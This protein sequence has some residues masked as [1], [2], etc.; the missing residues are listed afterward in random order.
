M[1]ILLK[2]KIVAEHFSKWLFGQHINLSTFMKC[3]KNQLWA[4]PAGLSAS[5]DHHVR[6]N[7]EN[8]LS[9]FTLCSFDSFIRF[10]DLLLIRIIFFSFQHPFLQFSILYLL[11]VC[12]KG[13][14]MIFSH[15]R[16]TCNARHNTHTVHICAVLVQ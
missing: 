10:L 8:T 11:F 15:S 6:F 2:W 7:G 13:F 12:S 4:R 14:D 9:Y 16:Y 1:G 3:L 5:S